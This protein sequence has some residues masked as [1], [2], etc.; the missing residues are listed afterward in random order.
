M[1]HGQEGKQEWI[2]C[3]DD[4]YSDLFLQDFENVDMAKYNVVSTLGM[5]GGWC[6][7]PINRSSTTSVYSSVTIPSIYSSWANQPTSTTNFTTDNAGCVA[8][9]EAYFQWGL[10]Q[11]MTREHFPTC[12]YPQGYLQT[13]T[14][15]HERGDMQSVAR[16]HPQG[17]LQTTTGEHERGDMQSVGREHPQGYLQTTTGEHERGDM[18]SVS[19]E[20]PQGYLQRTTGEHERGD[21]QS[22]SREHPQ[23]YLQT[24]TREPENYRGT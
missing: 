24:T 12:G 3:F 21:M 2:S 10:G 9:S 1:G 18:Q 19:R 16:E 17:Y 8:V 13:T 14:G 22:V 5:R 7:L 4:F 15:E 23:G 11:T 20:H 6:S